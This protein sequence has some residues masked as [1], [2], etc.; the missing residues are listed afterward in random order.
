MSDLPDSPISLLAS[1]SNAVSSGGS[2]PG[3]TIPLQAESDL[4]KAGSI[5]TGALPLSGSFAHQNES[6]VPAMQPNASSSPPPFQPPMAPM[7]VTTP[8]PP[9][10]GKMGTYLLMVLMFILGVVVGYVSRQFLS[11]TIRPQAEQQAVATPT[12]GAI[13]TAAAAATES[14]EL[15]PN[16]AESQEASAE[17]LRS[18]GEETATAA[19]TIRVSPTRR[20]ITSPR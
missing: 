20:P 13:P 4:T 11:P 16:T 12:A 7:V 5:N 19:P 6:S 3:Q 8:P 10:G 15:A 2:V 9:S 14:A 18:N 17:G 1:L